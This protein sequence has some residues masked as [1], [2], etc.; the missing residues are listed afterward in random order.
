V[1]YRIQCIGLSHFLFYY[2]Q[3]L[4]SQELLSSSKRF[5]FPNVSR[6]DTDVTIL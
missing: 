2:R 5:E 4:L 1:Q 3:D 6:F